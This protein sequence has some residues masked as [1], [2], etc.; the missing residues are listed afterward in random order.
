MMPLHIT[1]AL[2][3][4]HYQTIYSVVVAWLEA[5]TEWLQKKGKK[6][7]EQNENE[8]DKLKINEEIREI[9]RKKETLNSVLLMRLAISLKGKS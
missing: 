3:K 2:H 7:I 9:Q 5:D 6:V 4:F 1:E 8:K